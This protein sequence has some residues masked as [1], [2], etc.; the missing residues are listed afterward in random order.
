VNVHSI[1]VIV[2]ALLPASR[3][4]NAALRR[5]GWTVGHNVELGPCLVTRIDE[6][7]IG[8]NAKIGSFNVF[9]NLA[10]FQLRE[11]AQIGQW[12]WV[13]ASHHI[14]QAGGPGSFELGAQSSLTSRHYVDCTGG[15]RVGA[16][17]TI[18]GERSTFLTHGISWVSSDQTYDSIEIGSFCL[19]SSNVQVAPGAFVGDRV[20]VGMG[21]TIAGDLSEPGLYVQPRATLVKRD[22][23]GRYFERRQG[24]IDSVRPRS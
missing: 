13:T 11:G 24:H 16:Y 4:K 2:V 23:G 6:A 20:V 15:V 12:N 22:L 5:L 1:L 3:F 10:R 7:Q 8:D 18:A 21:A 9:R 19:L 14:R 17:T